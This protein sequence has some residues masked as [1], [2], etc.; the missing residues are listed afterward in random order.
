MGF[1]RAS[2]IGS[3]DDLPEQQSAP[4]IVWVVGIATLIADLIGAQIFGLE[5]SG[6]AWFIP[7]VFA[8]YALF[9][10][11]GMPK[12]PYLIW[13]P[14]F[15]LIIGYVL[16]ADAE[17]ALQRTVMLLAP[18]VI[19]MAVSKTAIGASEL[20]HI[21]SILDKFSVVF[22]IAILVN[23]GLALTGVLPEVTGLAPQ[24]T[25]A[26]LFGSFFAAKYALDNKN[27]AI[28]WLLF[29][30][31]PVI[32]VTRMGIL[33]VGLTLPLTGAPLPLWKRIAIVIGVA[34]IGL[35]VFNT[36]RVQNKMFYSGEG[37]IFDL[38]WDNP[39]LRTTGRKPILEA[40]ERGI[41]DSP[42]F[43]HGANASEQFILDRTDDELT[44]PHNDYLRLAFDYGYV[45]TLVFLV[46]MTAQL[47]HA[48]RAGY[49]SGG[50]ARLFLIAGAGAFVPFALFMSTDNII[51]YAAFFGNLQFM[52]LGA[53]YAALAN[54]EASPTSAELTYQ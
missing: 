13:M 22:F 4:V 19:G 47:L 49:R 44:H 31:V 15:G 24:A 35:L 27:A 29:A 3:A 2:N 50:A 11:P 23:S 25:T 38:S 14:W 30:T 9:T 7:L 51:L 21:E 52:I 17:H 18:M 26:A 37:T 20:S 28:K 34:A 46:C 12:F 8:L 43:G 1:W 32:A 6:F 39:N 42:L 54:E 48:L 40:M 16:F 5:V 10:T 36:E 41:A 33:A 45:G 53:G